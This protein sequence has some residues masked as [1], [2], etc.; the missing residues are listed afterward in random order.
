MARIEHGSA[1]SGQSLEVGYRSL[2]A[3]DAAAITALF[4]RLSDESVR[5]R[6]LGRKKILTSAEARYFASV[7][8]TDREAIAA[9]HG[10]DIVG[11]ARYDRTL[12]DTAE[13]AVVV[14]DNFQRQGHGVQLVSRLME[15][16]RLAGIRYF[17][18]ERFGD[19][20]PVV[21]LLGKAGLSAVGDSRTRS[22]VTH[23]K[24]RIPDPD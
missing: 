19:N 4:G 3:E 16:A 21:G 8:H 17:T 11:V 24:V 20:R 10:D 23:E 15:R 22:G 12:P 6:F 14:Q 5:R 13:I 1:R 7:D 2:Q 18:V 9:I